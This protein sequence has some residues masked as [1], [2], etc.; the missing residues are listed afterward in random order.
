[1]L[2]TNNG[3]P[4]LN[5]D[6]YVPPCGQNIFGVKNDNLSN[7]AQSASG[8]GV[9]GLTSGSV[10]N[11]SSTVSV[12]TACANQ[13][14][15]V[16]TADLHSTDGC[17]ATI[18]NSCESLSLASSDLQIAGGSGENYGPDQPKKNSSL[19]VPNIS[20]ASSTLVSATNVP[21]TDKVCIYRRKRPGTIMGVNQV[22]TEYRDGCLLLLIVLVNY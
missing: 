1:M 21:K 8:S 22:F 5:L 7:I 9:V 20:C 3:M 6:G 19:S 14:E 15:T 10:A 16:A 11:Q 17:S 4:T 12:L 13:S 18:E 2:L